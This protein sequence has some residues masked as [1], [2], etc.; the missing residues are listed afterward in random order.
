MREVARFD[1]KQP[2]LAYVDDSAAKRRTASPEIQ[3]LAATH[4]APLYA[5]LEKLRT[6]RRAY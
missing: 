6:Q 2:R 3:E 1:A 5:Q 4:L